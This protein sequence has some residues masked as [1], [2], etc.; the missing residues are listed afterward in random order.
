MLRQ[1]FVIGLLVIGVR[2]AATSAFG[3]LLFY[4][5][6][7]YFRPAAWVYDA[8]FLNALNLSMV[9]GAYLVVRVVLTGEKFKFDLRVVLLLTFVFIGWASA[10]NSEHS[11]HAMEWWS[12]YARAAMVCYVIS[13]MVTDGSRFRIVLLVIALSLGFEATK[14]GW[15][16]LVTNP[17]GKNQNTLPM[18]GDNNGVAVGMLM[19]VALTTAII[20]TSTK[21]WE[22][23]GF[24]F[25]AIGVAFRALQTYSRGGFLAAGMLTL[26]SVLRSKHKVKAAVGIGVVAGVLLSVLPPEYWER[27]STIKTSEEALEEV[28]DSSSLSRLHFWRVAVEMAND[29]PFLGV[30]FFSYSRAY[31]DYDFLE[32]LYGR[33]R[34]THSAWFAT[35]AELGYTGL[36]TFVAVLILGIVAAERARRAAVK[37]VLP[38][39]FLHYGVGIQSAFL[40]CAVGIT[41][42]SWQYYEM[43]W[44][45]IGLSMA[46]HNITKKAQADADKAASEA[47]AEAW[48]A[49]R[50]ARR[51][52]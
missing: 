9:S 3:A 43:L 48:R 26:T 17:G 52:A 49:S 7:A 36:I 38:P 24:S 51:T 19:L 20:R 12:Q 22:K 25:L 18:L 16:Q 6:I 13:I 47:A 32:G 4:L 44:H 30:G 21:K 40:S 8:A 41:F 1:I 31:N 29:H 33:D 45:V 46:L 15:A 34:E 5:W 23:L 27:M 11:A 50:D 14:Q 39:E 42:L 2:Y 10:Q 35:L 28:G 37:G